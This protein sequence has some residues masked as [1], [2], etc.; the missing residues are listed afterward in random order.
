MDDQ[1]ARAER[2]AENLISRPPTQADLV[3]LCRELNLRGARCGGGRTL[4][5]THSAVPE[6]FLIPERSPTPS[7]ALRRTM[8]ISNPAPLRSDLKPRRYRGV[9]RIRLVRPEFFCLSNKAV[10]FERNHKIPEN[11]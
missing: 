11:A 10:S 5:A 2:P 3:N 4:P 6:V 7:K 9:H 1:N 8:R